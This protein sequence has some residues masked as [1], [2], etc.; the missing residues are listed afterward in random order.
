MIEKPFTDERVWGWLTYQWKVDGLLNWG[1][2]RWGLATTGDGWRDPYKKPLS[3]PSATAGAATE[4]RA[5]STRATT[6]RHGLNDPY[7]PLVSSL[8]LEALR[9]GLEER[10]YLKP[11]AQTGT[12]SAAFIRD[13]VKQVTWYPYSIRQGNIFDFPKYT[14]STSV[15][16]AARRQL[17]ERIEAYQ[18]Q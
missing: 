14:K 5:C 6:P 18:G 15:F 1:M 12:G 9:D 3:A 16:A 8:R 7:A 2:N 13:V 17:A 4:R 11:A 10:E